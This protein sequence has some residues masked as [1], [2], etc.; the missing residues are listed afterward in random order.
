MTP[1]LE[2]DV[3]IEEKLREKVEEKGKER[4]KQKVFGRPE[5][6]E[7]L[8]ILETIEEWEESL[9]P[10]E[11]KAFE[12]YTGFG[13]SDIQ[14]CI[15]GL[16]C[17]GPLE[18]QVSDLL[19]ALGRAP[20]F[21][22]VSYRG[23]KLKRGETAKF[24]ANLKKSGILSKRLLATTQDP[25]I[26][27]R[28]ARQF[29]KFRESVL[30]RIEG[31]SGVSI[32]GI[33]KKPEELEVLF[34]PGSKFKWQKTSKIGQDQILVQV[35]EIVNLVSGKKLHVP[36]TTVKRSVKR[37]PALK[38]VTKVTPKPV[39]KVTPTLEP[40]VAP[41]KVLKPSQRRRVSRGKKREKVET[42]A[43]KQSAWEKSLTSSEKQAFK[44]YTGDRFIA[45]RKCLTTPRECD[46]ETLTLIKNL[47]GAMERAPKKA[48]TVYRA[49][50]MG[51][52]EDAAKFL[53]RARKGDF[54]DKSFLSTSS[55]F[56]VVDDRLDPDF[57]S[58]L[59]EINSKS[60]VD[61]DRLSAFAG[62]KEVLLRPDLKF[63]IKSVSIRDDIPVIK[64]EEL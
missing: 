59:L 6:K 24:L 51:S 11:E 20:T 55:K 22:G 3:T 26:A 38:P 63:R 21:E 53:A 8:D 57:H 18:K 52:E 7:E 34:A 14:D 58:I 48:Q 27:T 4:L 60:G 44:E 13:Y 49:V 29:G 23:M 28:F 61:I 46:S 19:G 39:T 56:S 41:K 9:T 62:E 32:T 50:S 47:R 2:P 35:K 64:L 31:K 37:V 16:D 33:S 1:T 42:F 45:V 25:K 40:K 43:N 15:L 54:T 17:S 36:V 5:E 12:T 30:L 10:A